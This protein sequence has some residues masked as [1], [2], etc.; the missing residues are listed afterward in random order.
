MMVVL[1]IEWCWTWMYRQPFEEPQRAAVLVESVR[2]GILFLQRR[3]GGVRRVLTKVLG[4][5]LIWEWLF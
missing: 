1:E 4:W 2:I 3:R 5:P